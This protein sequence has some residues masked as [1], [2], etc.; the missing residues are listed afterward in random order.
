MN[1]SQNFNNNYLF[2]VIGYYQNLLTERFLNQPLTFTKQIE[3]R[4]EFEKEVNKMKQKEN[5]PAWHTPLVLI[6]DFSKNSFY[7]EPKV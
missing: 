2:K 7:I 4:N 5:H 1:S 3:I 6:F